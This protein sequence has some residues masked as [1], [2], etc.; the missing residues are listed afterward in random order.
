MTKQ[1]PLHLFILLAGMLAFTGISCRKTESDLIPVNNSIKDLVVSPDF[2]FKTT[3]DVGIKVYTLDNTGVAVSNMRIDIYTDIPDNGGSLILSGMTNSNGLF[4]SDYKIA[5]G[6][7]SLAVGTTSIGFCNMQKA[8]VVNGSLN[9][10][11]GGKISNQGLKSLG[12]SYFKSTTANFYLMGT[13]N[14]DGVPNYLEKQND[15]IDASFLK[16]LNATL[17]EYQPAPIS[18]PQYFAPGNEQNLV[19]NDACNVWVTFVSEGAGYRNVLGYYIYKTGNPPATPADI[20]SVHIIFPNVSFSGSGGGLSSGNKVHIGTFAPGTEIGWVLVSDGYNGTSVTSGINTLFSDQN[21]NPEVSVDKKQHALLLNDIGRG[22]FLLSFEDMKRE[23]TG[24]DNDFNDAIFYV[25]ADPISS[26]DIQNI[27]MPRYVQADTDKDGVPDNFDAYPNDPLKAFDNFYPSKGNFG[28]LAFEDMWPSVGD[29]DFNDLVIDYNFN[30]I[31]NGKNEV[32]QIDLKATLTA[33]GA[34]YKNGF[35]IQLPVSP[36]LISSVTGTNIQESYIVLNGNGTEANQSKATI[37]VFDN[38]FNLLSDQGSKGV[39]VNTTPGNAYVTPK[40]LDITINLKTPVTLNTMGLPPYNPFMII[41]RVRE[42]E[43]HL[44]D[45]PPTDLA[46]KKLLGTSNDD[47]NPSSGRYYVTKSNLPFAIEI[48][49]HFD[50][51]IEHLPVT[52]AYLKFYEWGKSG[53]SLYYD[54]FKQ[55]SGYRNTKNIFSH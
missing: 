3:Q 43:V 47:S 21:L 12:Q 50:C 24:C 26:V 54:W 4:S 2:K 9:L 5:A 11:L 16:D 46:N 51:P 14:S 36:D 45:N 8:K 37:I 17:P 39:G 53:G 22:K 20:D 30:Q 1:K 32:V 35:G 42:N 13:Y 52:D 6:T 28:S 38:G 19:L 41:N 55:N 44:I 34:T 25:T 15:I 49:S 40:E 18:H 27:P 33:I 48:S 29:Y 10:T 31:T 23:N 7:D